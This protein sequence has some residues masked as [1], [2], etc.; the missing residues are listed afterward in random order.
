VKVFGG[1]WCL[2]ELPIVGDPILGLL[3]SPAKVQD[4]AAKMESWFKQELDKAKAGAQILVFLHI[5][6]FLKSGDEPDQYFNIPRE[7]RARYL[8]LLHEYG[9]RYV[10]A[11]HYHRNEEG[12]DGD[13]DLITSGPVGKPLGGGKSGLRMITVDGSKL[14]HKYYDFGDLPEK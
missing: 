12:K 6:L 2:R 14:A 5:S 7:T 1:A 4:E 11:G 8:K 13:L 10:F 9:V 3:K